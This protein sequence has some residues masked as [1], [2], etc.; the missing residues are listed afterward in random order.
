L[1]PFDRL[2]RH[3]RRLV[4]DDAAATD[5]DH[6]VRGSEV[7]RHVMRD[8]LEQSLKEHRQ[9]VDPSIV[10]RLRAGAQNIMLRPF[11]RWTKSQ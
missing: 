11:T 4:Q 5:I 6:G 2:D 1:T 8:G 10:A 3:H 9:S 7:D